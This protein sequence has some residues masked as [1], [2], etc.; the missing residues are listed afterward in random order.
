MSDN[1]NNITGG[2]R[3][4][5]GGSAEPLPASWARPTQTPRVGRI[6][7]WSGNNG[8]GSRSGSRFGTIG[9]LNSQ[10]SGGGPGFGGFGG[11]PRGGEDDDSDEEGPG[12][13]ESWFAGGERSGLSIQNPDNSSRM[14]GG[15]VVRDILRRAAEAGPPRDVSSRSGPFRGGGHTLGSDEVESTYIPDPDAIHEDEAPAVRNLTLWSDGFTIED[16]P[17]MDYDNP[18]DA[19]LLEQ[20]RSGQAPPHALNLRVGQSVD[21]RVAHRIHEAYV[22]PQGS[23]AFSGSGN[24]LGA[25][26]PEI[27]GVGSSSGSTSMPGQFPTSSQR[28]AAGAGERQSMTTRFEVDQSLPT[29]SVQLRLADGTRM[30]CRMN[31]TH[32]VGD[33]RNFINAARPENLTRPY[34]IGTTFPSRILD[35]LDITIEAAGLANSVVVQRWV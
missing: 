14:P 12:R 31:L 21:L 18:G 35:D 27:T 1:D 28:T 16:G 10:P 33:L 5:G 9:G 8:N 25:P 20:I 23:R 19:A 30:V 2:G 29:T 34:T 32:K 7:N 24:R 26:V 22:P 13:G 4:L 17:L 11:L 3:S 6:G 15:D